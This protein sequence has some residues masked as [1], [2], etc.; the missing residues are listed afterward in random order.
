M[1][2]KKKTSANKKPQV[3]PYTPD[4]ETDD[5]VS[6]YNNE[7]EHNEQP[8]YLRESTNG[9]S[10]FP[11]HDAFFFQDEEHPRYLRNDGDTDVVCE[12]VMEESGDGY[13]DADDVINGSDVITDS[14]IP[15]LDIHV[16][17]NH[18]TPIPSSYLR[19]SNDSLRLSGDISDPTSNERL[20][21]EEQGFFDQA[22]GKDKF[23]FIIFLRF[24]LIF[25]YFYYFLM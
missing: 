4:E 13:K 9:S 22:Y 7:E 11:M 24:F 16:D 14:I 25:F 18:E 12:Y 17:L 15:S 21:S 6:S 23:I 2:R 19:E 8:Q 20:P 1:P 3:S 5:L 10:N